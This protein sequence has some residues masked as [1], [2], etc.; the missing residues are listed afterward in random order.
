MGKRLINVDEVEEI[1]P[2]LVGK[3]LENNLIT[4][5]QADQIICAIF[6]D[7]DRLNEIR[8]LNPDYDI[9]MHKLNVCVGD[10]Q[11]RLVYCIYVEHK[12]SGISVY[13]DKDFDVQEVINRLPS[14]FTI[15]K[16][17]ELLPKGV[18]IKIHKYSI[19]CAVSLF[20]NAADY[21]K[22]HNCPLKEQCNGLVKP[23]C[24]EHIDN[25]EACHAIDKMIE[26]YYQVEEPEFLK[27]YNCH[28]EMIK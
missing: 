24:K 11:Y 18:N 5:E 23:E 27:F 15:E 6:N 7:N 22:D 20:S 2:V 10:S 28:L 17:Q 8:E 19:N 14:K 26:W 25:E 16:E 9:S 21:F 1:V 13:R 3:L 4:E 12:E